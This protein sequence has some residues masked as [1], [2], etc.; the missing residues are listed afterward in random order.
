MFVTAAQQFLATALLAMQTITKRGQSATQPSQCSSA[1]AIDL[2]N[3]SR[4]NAAFAQR[5][6]N[7][8]TDSYKLQP[9]TVQ[10]T[11]SQYDRRRSDACTEISP[12]SFIRGDLRLISMLCILICV[13]SACTPKKNI[14]PS[15]IASTLPI[16]IET[17]FEP[18]ATLIQPKDLWTSIRNNF[19]LDHA[20]Q[21]P[22]V[23]R[24]IHWLQR[25]Q[26][27][28][29]RVMLRAT[30]Y[31]YFTHHE[32]LNKG[33]PSELALL[34][35]IE[36]A[37]DPFAFSPEG[38][39]GLWQFMPGT[40]MGF[41]LE[42][43]WW[44]D[45][46]RDI[47]ASTYAALTYLI[48]LNRYFNGDWT[49]TLAAY[50][51]GEGTVRRAVRKNA[52]KKLSTRFWL[53]RLP[54]ETRSYV[55]RL[56]AIAAVI[57]HPEHY[58]MILPPLLDEPYFD[59]LDLDFQIDLGCAAS[60]A[61]ITKTELFRLNPGYNRWVTS[62]QNHQHLVLPISHIAEFK[63]NLAR[64]P[65]AKRLQWQQHRVKSHE[66]LSG[67]AHQYRIKLAQ[68]IKTNRL[69]NTVIQKNQILVI[70]RASHSIVYRQ[71]NIALGRQRRYGPKKIEYHAKANE[72]ISS[73]ARK[74]STQPGA[75]RFWNRLDQKNY[76]KKAQKIFIWKKIHLKEKRHYIVQTGDSLS[77]IVH[78]K[79]ISLT[80]LK[81]LN[82][83]LKQRR[84]L[85]PHDKLRLT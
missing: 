77:V 54:K 10:I 51:S 16:P 19:K 62:P 20:T 71:L 59:K 34:P 9:K 15:E 6:S 82:P 22:A 65:K 60:L 3:S 26:K 1:E 36:S 2:Q 11:Q 74:F 40:G 7:V 39:S 24:Q 66:T 68:L 28:F 85:K 31:L 8:S 13:L 56:L 80:Q 63:Y 23:R 5:A 67:I 12:P 45:A 25:H 84:Y 52:Q 57:A 4:C 49:L 81:K 83:W 18:I 61:G 41:G 21:Q 38:A 29:N 30:P 53:L 17:N 27:D 64:L 72:K 76:L 46:R 42:Q 73:I 75:I 33:L 55:P 14:A 44:Y 35:M 79:Q 32:V 50:D 69:K 48:Y 58:Q 78:K 70:P 37:Y 43:N 47:Y